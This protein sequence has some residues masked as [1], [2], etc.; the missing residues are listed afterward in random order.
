MPETEISRLPLLLVGQVGK[1]QPRLSIGYRVTRLGG[2]VR[3]A[4]SP[5]VNPN[6]GSIDRCSNKFYA[7][8]ER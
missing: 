4:G 8:N 7:L 1:R 6:T 2:T 3:Q 5:L